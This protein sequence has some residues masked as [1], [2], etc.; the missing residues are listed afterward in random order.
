MKLS[1]V[2]PSRERGAYLRHSLRTAL[3]IDDPDL[4][5][6][7][8][9]NQSTDNTESIVAEVDDPRLKYVRTEARVSMRQNFE[10]GLRHASGDY[11]IYFGDDDGILPGQFPF[12]RRILET[13]A[14]D[15]LSWSLPT[16]GWP[17]EGFG[18]RTGTMRYERNRSFG[19]VT[20][21]DTEALRGHMLACR[22]DRMAPMPALY[23]GCVSRAYL[24]GLR[25]PT[26][27]VFNSGIPDVHI[28]YRALLRGGRLMHVR[29]P[30][31]INGFSPASTGNAQHAYASTDARSEPARRFMA[32]SDADPVRDVLQLNL[33]VPLVLFSTLETIRATFPE[34]A[35]ATPDYTAWYRH[36]LTSARPSDT[37]LV[38]RLQELLSAH[39]ARTGTEAQFAAAEAAAKT[40]GRAPG[41]RFAKLAK[42]LARLREKVGSFRISVGIDDENTILTAARTSDRLLGQDYGAVLDG[43]MSQRDAWAALRARAKG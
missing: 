37:A 25:G 16:Y 35:T 24:E 27:E 1:I 15:V 26:G 19:P 21:L 8:T 23:H 20:E 31:S 12:L 5:V 40:S 41:G 22:Q 43:R 14:P 34:T 33:S 6:I 36:V 17:I 30:F 29:H 39:A 32:E 2:I 38:A 3:A 13:E 7:V 10:N 18:A 9:D 28:A 4:E 42:R 11:I